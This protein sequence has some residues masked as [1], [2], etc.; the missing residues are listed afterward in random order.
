[1]GRRRTVREEIADLERSGTL[2]AQQASTLRDAP[3]WSIDANELFAYLGGLIA[4]IGVTWLTIALVEDSSPV[5]IAIG[6][7][8]AGF[9]FLAV[10]R[11]VHRPSSWRGRLAEALVVVAI[12]L[13]AGGVGILANEAGA[14]SEHVAVVLSAACV[15][16]GAAFAQRTQFAGTVVV[17]IAAQLFVASL[18]GTLNVEDS[19]VS[20]LLFT[21]SGAA[22]IKAGTSRVGFGLLPRVVGTASY[23]LG[24]FVFGVMHDNLAST[25][26]ALAFALVLFAASTKLLR[27]EVIVGGAIGV[28]LTTSLLVTRLIDNQAIQGLAVIGIGIAMVVAASAVNKK[29][30]SS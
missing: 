9:A 2:T 15:V 12:G 14:A 10:A 11:F 19:L 16:L 17:V 27:L 20:A 30:R 4:A 25:I 24:T 8:V 6:M 28:A 5:G 18:I 3:Q 7:L 21:L 23:V 22:L 1:M 13:L 29:R 26:G